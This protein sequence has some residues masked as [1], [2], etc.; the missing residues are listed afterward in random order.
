MSTEPV[1]PDA[2]RDAAHAGLFA[3]LVVQHANMALIFAGAVPHPESGE[4]ETDLEA[5]QHFI[6]RLDM[7]QAKTRGNLGPQETAL[8]QQSLAAARMAFV[9]A[10]EARARTAPGPAAAPASPAAAG[11]PAEPPAAAGAA[12]AATAPAGT[13]E[14]APGLSEEE[15]KK[16]VKKY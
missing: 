13:A 11:T 14:P 7:L 6:D 16:F 4:R 8:L 9:H 2:T 10:V 12:A 5:A 3:D 1:T 15:R